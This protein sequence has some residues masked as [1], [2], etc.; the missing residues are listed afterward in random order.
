MCS[1]YPGQ[2][3]SQVDASFE[4]AFRLATNLRWLCS[5]LYAS[6]HTFFTAWPPNASQHK[7]IASQLYMPAL[8][9]AWTCE[10]TCETCVNLR[11]DLRIRLATHRKSIRKFWFCKLASIC[12]YLRVRLARA[13]WPDLNLFFLFTVYIGGN[14]DC[15]YV[16]ILQCI[17]SLVN[18]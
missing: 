10:P 17:H 4:L 16:S 11:A 6:R 1:Q 18:V 8:R 2:T 12:I 5:N 15:K 3:D 9:L 7:L 14:N 13:Q